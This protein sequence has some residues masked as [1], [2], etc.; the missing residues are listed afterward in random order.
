MVIFELAVQGQVRLLCIGIIIGEQDDDSR[1]A[2]GQQSRQVIA[3]PSFS[4]C[5]R[6][7]GLLCFRNGQMG[8]GDAGTGKAEPAG[9]VFYEI[10]VHGLL[11]I[12]VLPV[13]AAGSSL[14]WAMILLEAYRRPAPAYGGEYSHGP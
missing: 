8:T 6:A 5:Q 12:Q 7:D 9:G 10:S 3:F 13:P 2:M 4:R 14:P 11:P 1:L